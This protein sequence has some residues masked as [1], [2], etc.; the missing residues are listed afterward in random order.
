[1]VTCSRADMGL[2][3]LAFR[4]AGP[5]HGRALPM[6]S[7]LRP[8]HHQPAAHGHSNQSSSRTMRST[9][10]SPASLIRVGR[11]IRNNRPSGLPA[12][13]GMAKRVTGQ[14]AAQRGHSA[15]LEAQRQPGHVGVAALRGPPWERIGFT[16]DWP[17]LTCPSP[18]IRDWETEPWPR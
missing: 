15:S 5:P 18:L 11:S 3:L 4:G 12:G 17:P 16:E 6:P 10:P 1:M 14:R 2:G 7:W 13:I 8:R 9:E